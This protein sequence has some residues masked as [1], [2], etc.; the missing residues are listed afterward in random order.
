MS[1]PYAFNILG[2]LR[3]RL[4]SSNWSLA[5]C[6]TFRNTMG[7]PWKI[8]TSIWKNLKLFVQAWHQSTLMAIFWRWKPFHSFFFHSFFLKRLK[9]GYSNWQ[10]GTVTSWES[11]KKVFLEKFFPM[12]R[13]IL[14]RKKISGIQQNQGESFAAYYER[15]KAL[16]SSCPQ[17]QMKEELLIQYF[18]EGLLPIERQMLDA[19]GRWCFGQQNT[20]WCKDPN[21]QS[22]LECTTIRRH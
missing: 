18:Y 9:I 21:C 14:L 22:S 13:V 20:N 16:V 11:M 6:T 4:M 5:C 12:S 7:C 15:F 3:G 10:P 17:H 19:S 1:C 8:Q 2:Q